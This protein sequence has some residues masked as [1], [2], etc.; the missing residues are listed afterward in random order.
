MPYLQLDVTEHYPTA[1]KQLLAKRLGDIFASLMQA[2]VNRITITIRELG[3]GAVWRC[4]DGD[5]RPAALLMCDIRKGRSKELR[6]TLAKALV[7]ACMEILGL[8]IDQLNVEF[9]QHAGDEMYHPMLGGLS[10]DWA[11]GEK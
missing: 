8:R 2:N 10:D 1:T 6:E 11:P 3:Q 7:A 4:S 9:T 5:P